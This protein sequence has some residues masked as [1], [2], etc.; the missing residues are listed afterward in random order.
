M[1][2]KDWINLEKAGWTV[3]WG[4]LTFCHDSY[5]KGAP[6]TCKNGDCDGHPICKNAKQ[7]DKKRF[8]GAMAQQA[9][10]NFDSVETAI[11]EW[12][13]ITGQCA[14]DEGCSCCGQPHYFEED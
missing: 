1:T 2:D 10:K 6:N 12:E 14:S 5:Y 3:I 8:L 11:E 13:E 9:H 4:G 7:A